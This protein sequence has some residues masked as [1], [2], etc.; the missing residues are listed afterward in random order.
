MNLRRLTERQRGMT[1][2]IVIVLLAVMFGLVLAGTQSLSFLKTELKQ[3]ERD[4]TNRLA[5]APR[6]SPAP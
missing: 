5:T 1:V 6:P 3:I 4:Q 2:L